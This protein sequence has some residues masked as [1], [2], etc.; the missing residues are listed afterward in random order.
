MLDVLLDA[1]CLAKYNLLMPTYLNERQNPITGAPPEDLERMLDA[2]AQHFGPEWLA[3]TGDNPI[4]VLWKRKDGLATN[5]LLNLG[6]AIEG[7]SKTHG[8]WLK[9][10][11][12][13][14]KT[15]DGGNRAGAIFELLALNLYQA[16]GNDVVPTKEHNPGYDV[17]VRLAN[18]AAVSVSLKNH[19]VSSNERDFVKRAKALDG[20]YQEW[21][22][23][24]SLNG[25][26][27][28]IFLQ[29]YP[30][31]LDWAD[32]ESDLQ[33]IIEN[34]HHERTTTIVPKGRWRIN[35]Q[36]VGIEY[37]PLSV[38]AMTSSFFM[39]VRAHRNE[40]LNFVENIRVG[41]QNLVKHSKNL[42]DSWC[43][44]LLVRLSATASISRCVEWADEYFKEYPDEP[45]GVIILYQ[46][47][48]VTEKGETSLSHCIMPIA[49]PRYSAWSAPAN[50]APRT[51]PNMTVVVGLVLPR[52]AKKALD[53]GTSR[54]DIDDCYTFQRGDIYRFYKKGDQDLEVKL[55]NPAPGIMIHAEV[56]VDGES[57]IMKM[58]APEQ[59]DLMLLP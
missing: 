46:A 45:V 57:R 2:V 13:V 35:R 21:L 10:Q 32:L 43:P 29:E 48:V 14:I 31:A 42:P 40:Q 37:H 22:R 9:R 33:R 23:Q 52:P 30:S 54:I 11:V 6:D 5:E 36:D 39:C 8:D 50:V 47:T 38:N 24:Q 44:T 3:Q 53:N 28:R 49:G 27:F 4:Q 7:F 59:G 19:G 58:V 56:E 51:M 17:I 20:K 41:C 1:F 15:G 25:A 16:A 18:D 34:T 55:S 12:G 26:E